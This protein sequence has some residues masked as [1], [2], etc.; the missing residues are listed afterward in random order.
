MVEVVEEVAELAEPFRV[1]RCF[2]FLLDLGDVVA[3]HV[4]TAATARPSGDSRL[5]KFRTHREREVRV[6]ADGLA[7][8]RQR[9]VLCERGARR[10]WHLDPLI[11]KEVGL[12][13]HGDRYVDDILTLRRRLERA[14]FEL[15]EDRGGVAGERR[16]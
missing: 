7:C 13:A 8:P 6:V 1:E 9:I 5:M 15:F 11:R 2:P 16:W 14:D 10:R 4:R 12:V 3:D